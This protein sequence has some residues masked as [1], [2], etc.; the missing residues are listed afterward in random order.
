MP[1]LVQPQT[2]TSTTTSFM[3]PWPLYLKRT[4]ITTGI[5]NVPQDVALLVLKDVPTM[6]TLNPLVTGYEVKP[7][8][9]STYIITDTLKIMSFYKAKMKYTARTELGDEGVTFHVKAG[10]GM[11]STN[12]WKSHERDEASGTVEVVEESYVEAPFFLIPFIIG[13]VKKSHRVLMDRLTAKLEAKQK[14]P[15]RKT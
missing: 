10:G 4:V 5:I 9:A 8:D 7:D 3:R 2:Y 15:T 12:Y 6:I 11:M 1:G 13:T 14:Q